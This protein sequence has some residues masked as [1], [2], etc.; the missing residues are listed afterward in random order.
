MT[1]THPLTDD[2]YRTLCKVCESAPQSIALA[3]ACIRCGLPAEDEKTRA[4]A[5]LEYAKRLKQEFFPM[6]P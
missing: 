2:D 6:M 4:E 5:H 3:E 1:V